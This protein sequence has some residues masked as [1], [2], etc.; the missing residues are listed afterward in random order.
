[1]AAQ[2]DLL[3]QQRG[4]RLAIFIALIGKTNVAGLGEFGGRFQG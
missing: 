3:G 1:M 4:A 2:F